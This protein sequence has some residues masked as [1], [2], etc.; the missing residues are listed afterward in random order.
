M[1]KNRSQ[2]G[3]NS[4]NS[5]NPQAKSPSATGGDR[6][7]G[8]GPNLFCLFLAWVLPGLGHVCMGDTKRGL[9]LGFTI[10]S[11]FLSGL[12][13][14]GVGVVDYKLNRAWFFGQMFNGPAVMLAVVREKTMMSTPHANVGSNTYLGTPDAPNAYAPSFGRPNEIGILYTALAGLLNLFIFY[15]VFDRSM[16]LNAQ[17]KSDARHGGQI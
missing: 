10:C 9:I 13:I 8:G 17:K 3:E 11:L 1:Q 16:T 7:S 2:Q 14:G 5:H 15:D 4:E 12:L 6:A